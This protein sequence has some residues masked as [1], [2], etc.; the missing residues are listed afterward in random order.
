MKIYVRLYE[1]GVSAFVAEPPIHVCAPR[2]DVA[3]AGLRVA[4]K[5]QTG[6][7]IKN[8]EIDRQIIR[9]QH[10]ENPPLPH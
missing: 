5:A 7:H 3:I 9:S 6:C 10:D 1:T 8:A 4:V 2:E